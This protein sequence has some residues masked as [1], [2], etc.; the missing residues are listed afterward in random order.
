MLF[1]EMIGPWAFKILNPSLSETEF[2][3][4][5][6]PP[7]QE[8][9]G[10]A[11]LACFRLAKALKKDL[12]QINARLANYQGDLADMIISL[13]DENKALRESRDVL[14]SAL[15]VAVRHIGSEFIVAKNLD[16]PF[17]E[18]LQRIFFKRFIAAGPGPIF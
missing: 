13:E 12:W 6:G 11:T 17:D 1:K 14:L 15:T 8:G 7:G 2:L 4:L 10:D 3:E 16:K 9:M 18:R 5:I